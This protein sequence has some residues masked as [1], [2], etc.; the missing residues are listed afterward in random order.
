[1]PK[2]IL[3]QACLKALFYYNPETGVLTW[4]SRPRDH[5]KTRRAFGAWNTKYAGREAGW[6]NGDGYLKV[7]ISGNKFMAHRIIYKWLYDQE[8]P[9]IDHKNH[10]RHDNLP[11]N[12]R[13]ATPIINQRN[14][15][16][17]SNNTSG[18]LGVGKKGG[19][20]H[21]RI[22]V[23]RKEINL[24]YFDDI[25]D[26]TRARQEADTKYGFHKNHGEK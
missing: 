18:I 7:T 2:A 12:L 20:W 25:N 11:G 5:F 8:P 3:S 22:K 24:G 10:I 16:I 14:Q 6:D 17:P 23:D 21:A 4:R 26:A 1:M 9:Q 15:K 19:K 13:A